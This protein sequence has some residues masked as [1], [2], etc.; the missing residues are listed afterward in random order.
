MKQFDSLLEVADR[1]LSP[2][3]CPWDLEQTFLTL[4][5]YVI[6]EAHEVIEAV[7]ADDDKKIIEEL[8]DLLY[9]IVFYAKLAEK[10]K[11]FSIKEIITAVED[12]LIRRHPHV[13]GDIEVGGAE[14]V[15]QNWE[16]IK[17]EEKKEEKKK[18]LWEEFPPTL[19]LLVKAQKMIKRI[20]RSHPDFFSSEPKQMSEQEVGE[21]LLFL[22]RSSEASGV[23]AES[24]LRRQIFNLFS[25]V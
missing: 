14:E 1:L 18:G 9:T 12:K 6:E 20:K 13:F 11:R 2:E 16:K 15:A 5:P 24:A 8:G 21:Q 3:G 25:G 17:K 10:E 4:Q 23:D 19:P 7:D 22:I